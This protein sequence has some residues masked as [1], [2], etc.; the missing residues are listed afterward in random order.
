MDQDRSNNLPDINKQGSL[1]T[2]KSVE[3]VF[4]TNEKVGIWVIGMIIFEMVKACSNGKKVTTFRWATGKR[5]TKKDGV[6][7]NVK[8]KWATTEKF[9][10]RGKQDSS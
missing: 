5:T 10:N 3:L 7:K 6:S 9:Q 1:I 2:A 4:K 8:K